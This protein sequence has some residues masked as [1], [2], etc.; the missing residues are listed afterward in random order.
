LAIL[1]IARYYGLYSSRTKGKVNKDGSLAKFRYNAAPRKKP[2]QEP[3]TE[4]LSN[5]ASRLSWAMLI[6]KVYE[7]DT[8]ICSKCGHEM[9]VIVI[10]I[11]PYEV[12]KILECHKRNNLSPFDKFEIKAS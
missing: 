2:F 9:R 12:N 8:L 4:I 3:E 5:K 1:R 6:Q 7:V 11:D 10:I